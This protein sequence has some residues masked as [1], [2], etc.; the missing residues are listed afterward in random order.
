MGGKRM[1]EGVRRYGPPHSCPLGRLLDDQVQTLA[2]KCSPADIQEELT[3]LELSRLA[4]PRTAELNIGTDCPHRLCADWD[5]S[6][7]VSFTYSPDE[8]YLHVYIL[9]SQSQN[10]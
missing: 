1:T 7:A 4:K 8:S 5:Y 6:L 2:C 3:W 10:L 9:T